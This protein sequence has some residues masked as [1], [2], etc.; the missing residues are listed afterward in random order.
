MSKHSV[1]IFQSL[2]Y[3]AYPIDLLIYIS[4]YFQLLESEGLEQFVDPRTLQREIADA[5]D[6]TTEDIDR[7]ARELY[8]APRD[9]P[10][11]QPRAQPRDQPP[12]YDDYNS[13][14]MQDYNRYSGDGSDS[15]IPYHHHHHATPAYYED[16]HHARMR[17]EDDID[18]M[19]YVT[20]L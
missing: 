15:R 7:A 10:R 3:H 9:Q 17:D 19:V 11:D 8:M 20:T 1:L 5:H 12:Y 13:Q 18:P 2:F 4:L 6:L 14:E 16:E